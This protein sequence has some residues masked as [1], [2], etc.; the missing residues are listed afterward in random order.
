M[1]FRERT[2]SATTGIL[3]VLLLLTACGAGDPA[4][5]PSA[6]AT[7]AAARPSSTAHIAI[8]TPEQNEVVTGPTTPL[9]VRL[10]GAEIVSQTSTDLQPDQGHLH[11]FL[12]GELVSMTSST[13]TTLA[14][15][16]PGEHLV[17]VEFVAT[18][19]APFDPRVIAA[20][21]F[22]VEA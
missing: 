16:A 7:T 20:V 13:D 19:H 9:K 15:L 14:D 21:S 5:S 8:S 1:T 12:D 18:D 2:R 11:V 3:G 4:A 6:A 10:T 17:K 22:E